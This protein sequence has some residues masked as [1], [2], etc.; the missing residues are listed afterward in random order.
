MIKCPLKCSQ[1]HLMY[2]LATT[3]TC[4]NRTDYVACTGATD[5]HP[6]VCN[7]SQ[8]EKECYIK[9]TITWDKQNNVFK[10]NDGHNIG[11]TIITRHKQILA[12]DVINNSPNETSIHWH[13]MHQQNMPFMDGVGMVT[14]WPIP[15]NGGKFR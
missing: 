2:F 15:G 8:T 14:Q 10:I 4:I 1:I 7:C 6:P 3:E 12:V 9:L 13:G 5:Y 11:P